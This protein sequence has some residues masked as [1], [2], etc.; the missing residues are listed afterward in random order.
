[1][2]EQR[3]PRSHAKLLT[4]FSNRPDPTH[5]TYNLNCNYLEDSKMSIQI[6]DYQARTGFEMACFQS[7]KK[8]GKIDSLLWY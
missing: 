4:L 6:D 5:L 7:P 1:M 3:L 8:R 2:R